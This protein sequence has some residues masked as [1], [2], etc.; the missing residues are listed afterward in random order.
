[1]GNGEKTVAVVDTGPLIH[2]AQIGNLN[3]LRVFNDLHIPGAV[4]QE[5]V[6][7]GNVPQNDVLNLGNVEVHQLSPIDVLNFIQTRGM[8]N[9]HIGERECLYLCWHTRIGTLLT[10]DLAVRRAAQKAGITPVGSLGVIVRAH[11]GRVISRDKAENLLLD[12]Y[13]HSNLYV[14]R[15]ITEIAIEQLHRMSD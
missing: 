5:A 3:L 9:L 10:D 7:Q 13:H 11:V 15:A 6:T 2:L 4:W 14:T 1:M 8:E 12:L